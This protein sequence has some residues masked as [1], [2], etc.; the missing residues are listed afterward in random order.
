M[1]NFFNGK[2]IKENLKSNFLKI[3]YVGNNHIYKHFFQPKVTV[4]PPYIIIY[5]NVT[6]NINDCQEGSAVKEERTCLANKIIL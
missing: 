6:I 3:I 5:Y 1:T 2:E 4:S